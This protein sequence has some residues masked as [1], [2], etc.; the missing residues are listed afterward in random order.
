MPAAISTVPE[1]TRLVTTIMGESRA[2]CSNPNWRA[3]AA[4]VNPTHTARYPR[5]KM[6][7]PAAAL[8]VFSL[9]RAM[10]PYSKII[11]AALGS[12][13]AAIITAHIA[14]TT[15]VYPGVHIV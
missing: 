12:I 11:G 6:P 15:A 1:I 7:A 10:V 8:P 14:R 3:T 9:R 4:N 13:M 2:A 5:L